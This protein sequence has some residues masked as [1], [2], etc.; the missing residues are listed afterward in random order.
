MKRLLLLLALAGCDGAPPVLSVGVELAP[1]APRINEFARLRLVVRRC[2][3]E[4]L[5]FAEDLQSSG[6]LSIEAG[7]VPGDAFYVWV[8][9]WESCNTTCVE[10]NEATRDDDCR[11]I[12]ETRSERLRA[13]DCSDW[14]RLPEG[15]KSLTLTLDATSARCPPV[16]P[17]NGCDAIE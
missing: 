7:V 16:V 5:A 2:G 10:P 6:A 17:A 12:T 3:E 1:T 13:E 14:L 9:G 15:G 11:C 8:Q 4:D